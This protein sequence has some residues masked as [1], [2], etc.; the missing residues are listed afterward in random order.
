M[1]HTQ[2]Y[3]TATERTRTYANVT[4]SV[5]LRNNVECKFIMSY[6]STYTQDGIVL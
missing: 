1:F 5:D 4:V 2:A 6:L 3:C